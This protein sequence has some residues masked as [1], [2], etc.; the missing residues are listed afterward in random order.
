MKALKKFTSLFLALLM[1]ISAGAAMTISS[2]AEETGTADFVI[3]TPDELIDLLYEKAPTNSWYAGKT[4]VLANDIDMTGKTWAWSGVSPFKGLS[5]QGTLDGQGY[6]IKNLT[7]TSA[8][9]FQNLQNAV[10]K[11]ISFVDFTVNSANGAVIAR[12]I[13]SSGKKATFENVYVKAVLNIST[14]G[15]Y[16]GGFLGQTQSSNTAVFH[17]C[18]S[19]CTINGSTTHHGIGGFVGLTNAGGKVEITDC[20]FIGDLSGA[21]AP[22]GVAGFIGKARNT[23]TI[24]RCV[25]LGKINGSAKYKASFAVINYNDNYSFED[26]YSANNCTKAIDA[27]SAATNCTLNLKFNGESAYSATASDVSAFNTAFSEKEGFVSEIKA[28]NLNNSMPA[29]AKS[30]AWTVTEGTVAYAD[31]KTVARLIPKT[32]A[33]MTMTSPVEAKYLQ[34]RNNGEGYDVRFVGTVNFEDLTKYD[35]VGF[36][37]TVKKDGTVIAFGSA[38]TG[39]VFGSIIANGETVT[40]EKLSAKGLNIVEFGTFGNSETYEIS[41]TAFAKTADGTVIYDYSGALT[42]KVCGGVLVD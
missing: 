26:C 36:E 40:A 2:S 35:K 31:G 18:V 6:A 8:G 33:F 28:D 38:E 14:T 5:F 15:I 21:T 16:A 7:V 10:I 17:N 19:E 42:V 39:K 11:N 13:G 4:V 25:S 24:T 9:M 37:Y 41:V 22:D 34:I 1:I 23:T 30:G 20:A 29:I 32:V 27:T 12:D 3:S